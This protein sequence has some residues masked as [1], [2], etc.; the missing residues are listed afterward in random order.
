MVTVSSCHG[1]HAGR[2]SAL[3]ALSLLNACRQS[4]PRTFHEEVDDVY[5]ARKAAEL[6]GAPAVGSLD[7]RTQSI[8]GRIRPPE[9]AAKGAQ[10]CSDLL[11]CAAFNAIAQ[12]PVAIEG[13][14]LLHLALRAAEQDFVESARAVAFLPDAFAHASSSPWSAAPGYYDWLASRAQAD[15]VS[16]SM[17]AMVA[18]W[19]RSKVSSGQIEWRAW[20]RAQLWKR[21]L[22]TAPEH[23]SARARA[24]EFGRIQKCLWSADERAHLIGCYRDGCKK[25]QLSKLQDN[26]FGREVF[27]HGL[28]FELARIIHGCSLTETIGV[29]RS[30]L[31]LEVRLALQITPCLTLAAIQP[32]SDGWEPSLLSYDGLI[33]AYWST[34]D[35]RV[36]R[37][38]EALAVAGDPRCLSALTKGIAAWKSGG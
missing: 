33:A 1:M 35:V 3:L 20:D 23:P 8:I 30:V 28:Q 6:R 32:T 31:E 4:T 9:L 11:L 38:V 34:E 37:T 10:Y 18:K 21:F 7:V 29:D 15:G 25:R 2:W 13:N 14:A 22:A 19:A 16:A 12:P 5:I 36:F 17:D 26:K 27:P 24:L